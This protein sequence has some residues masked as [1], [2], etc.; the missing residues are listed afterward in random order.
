MALRKIDRDYL[1][2][3]HALGLNGVQM[4]RSLRVT[5][6]AIQ[7]VCRELGL[8]LPGPRNQYGGQRFAKQV[9]TPKPE[10]I[11]ICRTCGRSFLQRATG[12]RRAIYHAAEC[13][14]SRKYASPP[15]VLVRRAQRAA[16]REA[17]LRA[18]KSGKTLAEIGATFRLTK[19]RVRQILL[20]SA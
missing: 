11:V 5:P 8:M 20:Q 13:R 9:R 18:R 12:G 4:A 17:M 3:L 7:Y 6:A 10:L 1:R 16:R 15:Q 19:E 14:S 2:R